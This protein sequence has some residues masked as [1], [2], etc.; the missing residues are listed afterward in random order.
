MQKQLEEKEEKI[1]QAQQEKE[2]QLNKTKK[3]EENYNLLKY[4]ST[5]NSTPTATPSPIPSIG[6]YS[7]PT[8]S[9]LENQ[10]TS[11]SSR[12]SPFGKY[13]QG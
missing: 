2:E 13:L 3:L 6:D 12:S 9:S 1:K 4:D 7:T 11:R 8:K 5:P 10:N